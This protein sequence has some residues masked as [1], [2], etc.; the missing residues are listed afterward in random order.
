MGGLSLTIVD[1]DEEITQ[2]LEAD[3][4]ATGLKNY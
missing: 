4:Q 2:L 3:G 1:L